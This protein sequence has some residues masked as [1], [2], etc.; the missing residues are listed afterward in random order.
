MGMNRFLVNRS[1][2]TEDQHA[3]ARGN[4]TDDVSESGLIRKHQDRQQLRQTLLIGA[5]SLPTSAADKSYFAGLRSRIEH[6]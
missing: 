4:G 6:P 1:E 5:S 3:S 2:L